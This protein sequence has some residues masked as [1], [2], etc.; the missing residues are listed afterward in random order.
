M[1]ISWKRVLTESGDAGTP[2]A[3]NL[4]NASS[5]PS[6]SAN[7]LNAGTVADNVLPADCGANATYDNYASWNIEA[8][9]GGT[10]AINS[11]N[12]VQF[13][14]GTSITTTRSGN[15]ITITN[16]APVT[17]STV[18]S[19]GALM[20]SE[21]TSIQA[22]KSL[23]QGLATGDDVE[24]EAGI[25]NAELTASNISLSA[26]SES[27]PAVAIGSNNDGF[28]HLS[29][30][31]TGINVIVN[32]VQEALFKDGGDFHTDG[33]VY[34]YSSLTDSDKRLKENIK[35]LIGNL[36]N[37]MKLN[38]VN[39]NWKVR[40][41][42]LDIGFI[43][44]DMQNIIPE[45]VKEVGAIGQ[46]AMFLHDEYDDSKM[47]TIDYAKLVPVLVGAI[48]ELKKEI[49]DLKENCCGSSK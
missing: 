39:F 38:P 35:P 9:S 28:Y 48:Q 12:D 47:L 43:A 40:D 8:D 29:S 26:G 22:V 5:L 11:G 32:N 33:D 20:D 21:C 46:T 17:T 13:I 14:G 23:D 36:D 6:H 18:T 45:V 31:D 19:A 4:T 7:L 3:I 30:G 37:E 1:A 49:R 44:Q 10:T 25:F 41:K 42:K 24:F 2:S 16:D 27:A 34:A 15:D